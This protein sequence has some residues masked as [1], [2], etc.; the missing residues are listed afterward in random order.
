MQYILRNLTS[1]VVQIYVF[2]VVIRSLLTIAKTS[3]KTAQASS[4]LSHSIAQISATV[5]CDFTARY[6]LQSV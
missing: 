5:D 4:K 1:L 3:W 2:S 6:D